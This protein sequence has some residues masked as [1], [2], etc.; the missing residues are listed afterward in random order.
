MGTPNPDLWQGGECLHYSMY[1]KADEDDDSMNF[2]SRLDDWCIA[3]GDEPGDGW[4]ICN[5]W[6][7]AYAPAS[8]SNGIPRQGWEQTRTAVSFRPLLYNMSQFLAQH[9]CPQELHRLRKQCRH[10]GE[11]LLIPEER[12]RSRSRRSGRARR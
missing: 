5:H 8:V 12:N 3:K 9:A 11:S 6:D 1:V 10:G 4:Y 7:V 2:M